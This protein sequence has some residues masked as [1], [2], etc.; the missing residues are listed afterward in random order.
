MDDTAFR[1]YFLFKGL[2]IFAALF[3][4]E[5]EHVM[6]LGVMSIA[7][8]TVWAFCSLS[9]MSKAKAAGKLLEKCK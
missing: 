8:V 5:P 1:R 7:C 3:W 6:P 4:V 9:A 2:M